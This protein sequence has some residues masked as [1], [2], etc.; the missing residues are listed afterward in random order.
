MRNGETGFL[1]EKDNPKELFEKLSMLL[2]NLDNASR[3][4]KKGKEFVKNNFNWDKIC[5]DFLNHLKKHNIGN[6]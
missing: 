1:I 3:M 2:N 5:D 4:G 6:I